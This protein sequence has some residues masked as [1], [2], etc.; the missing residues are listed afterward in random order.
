MANP[1]P[2]LQGFAD[3]EIPG[4]Q[5]RALDRVAERQ[6][7]KRSKHKGGDRKNGL[8]LFFDDGFRVLLDEA[9]R[10]RDISLTGYCRRAIAAFLAHDLGIPFEDVVKHTAS[11][12]KYMQSGG[13]TGGKGYDE[14]LGK[15]DWTIGSLE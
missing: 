13:G 15:G 1:H 14:G 4:W 2:G 11:P 3:P 10:R 5:Q 8:Y 9:A 6:S 7:P 12:S